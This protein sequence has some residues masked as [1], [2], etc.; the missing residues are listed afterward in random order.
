MC[1]RASSPCNVCEWGK[2]RASSSPPPTLYAALIWLISRKRKT[3][4]VEE[5]Y[6][7]KETR[8]SREER[9]TTCRS[10]WL[11][12]THI[13]IYIVV[14]QEDTAVFGAERVAGRVFRKIACS[15]GNRATEG[16]KAAR[17]SSKSERRTIGW[18]FAKLR[19]CRCRAVN[20]SVFPYIFSKPLH[21]N[22][23]FMAIFSMSS[24]TSSYE[25]SPCNISNGMRAD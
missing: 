14:W 6:T 16:S 10:Q 3:T 1:A 12:W 8:G 15:R 2:S 11:A 25:P 18:Y 5:R 19:C 22:L 17:G 7:W 21:D 23:F 20:A 4:G 9:R 24:V 13:Y